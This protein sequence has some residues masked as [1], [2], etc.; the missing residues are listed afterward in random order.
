MIISSTQEARRSLRSDGLGTPNTKDRVRQPLH[1]AQPGWFHEVLKSIRWMHQEHVK[2]LGKLGY[3]AK[4]AFWVD[5]AC[6]PFLPW[7]TTAHDGV[8]LSMVLDLY[9]D[10]YRLTVGPLEPSD[11][12]EFTVLLR[13]RYYSVR[14][15]VEASDRVCPNGT[16]IATAAWT[17]AELQKWGLAGLIVLWTA[18]EWQRHCSAF[19]CR[20][21]DD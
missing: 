20:L 7:N 5:F 8:R 14:Q 3:S 11:R 12:Q 2:E 1:E 17:D 18:R 9:A 6:L 16:A 19:P 4:E 21:L 15:M 13:R 10:I